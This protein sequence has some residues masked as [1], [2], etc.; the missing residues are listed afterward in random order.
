MSM[1]G[2]SHFPRSRASYARKEALDAKYAKNGRE[3]RQE[4][5]SR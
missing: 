3:G 2:S 1:E 4:E 5:Q